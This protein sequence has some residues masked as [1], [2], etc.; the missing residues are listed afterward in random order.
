MINLAQARF[1]HLTFDC[2]GTLIDWESG[3]LHCL[4]PLFQ[5]RGKDPEPA[6][7]LKSFVKNEAALESGP[8]HPYREILKLACKNV[9]EDFHLTLSETECEMLP[10]QLPD[11]PPFSD[12]VSV[13]H[14]L[15]RRYKLVIL[16][17][18]DDSLFAGTASKLGIVFDEIITAEQLHSYKPGTAHFEEAIKRLNV[19]VDRILH[20]A[21]SLYH[22]H[23]PAKKLGFRTVLIKRPSILAST[24]LAPS[25]TAQPDWQFD[26]L[27]TLA[28]ELC[29][30]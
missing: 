9:G 27:R 22:D 21:Q 12:T 14:Q 25:A 16:S 5:R 23:V 1:S 28:E 6:E 18:T 7:I 8:W 13:L 11:W 17:N 4:K 26:S 30:K 20:V 24:G 2:Y 19:P 15:R 10:N 3:I 29:Q